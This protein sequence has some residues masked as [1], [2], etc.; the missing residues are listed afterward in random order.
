M[1][2]LNILLSSILLGCLSDGQAHNAPFG[3]SVANP[4]LIITGLVGEDALA[5]GDFLVPF[6][7]SCDS[8]FFGNLQGEFG[9]Q[10]AW[11]AGVGLAYRKII[12][13]T[14]IVG[15]YVF[16]DNNQSEHHHEFQVVSPGV[17]LISNNWDVR[18]NG[19]IPVS[20]KTKS[21]NPFFLTHANSCG[22]NDGCEF[23][24]FRGHQQFEHQFVNL[25]Q[26]G[27]GVDGEIGITLPGAYNLQLHAGGY[28]FDLKDFDDVRGVEARVGLPINPTITLTAETS[29]DNQQRGRVVAGLQFTFGGPRCVNP[30]SIASH[31]EDPIMRNLGTVGRGNG[32]PIISRRK[33]NGLVLTRDN[34]FFFSPTGTAPF[35]G[36]NSGTFENPLAANQFS[37][38]TVD[39]VFA[40]TGDGSFYFATGTY[41]IQGAGAPNAVVTLHDH[42][43]IVGRTADFKCSPVGDERPILLGGL[44]FTGNNTLDSIQLINALVG[45]TGGRVVALD[46]DAAVNNHVCNSTIAASAI[47]NG[48]L[49]GLENIAIGIHANDSEL[50][51]M[52][53]TVTGTAIV[54]GSVSGGGLNA[55]AGIGE[56]GG[57]AGTGGNA[58]DGAGLFF[59]SVTGGNGGP[60]IDEQGGDGTDASSTITI[61]DS[62]NGTSSNITRTFSNNTF[63]LTDVNVQ[64]ISNITD[65]LTEFSL[66]SAIGIGVIAGIGGI[67]G[68][69]GDGGSILTTIVRGGNGGDASGV[70]GIGG[71]GGN[72]FL[73]VT[74]GNAGDGGSATTT[75]SFLDN[76]FDVRN[77]TILGSANVDGIITVVSANIAGGIGS[78]GG[79]GGTGGNGGNGGFID[80]A[81]ATAGSGGDA[82]NGGTGG[83]GGLASITLSCGSGGNGGDAFTLA[84]F[85]RNDFTVINTVVQAAATGG[86]NVSG[87]SLNSAVG[88]GD[89]AG[90]SGLG[91]AG[92]AGGSLNSIEAQGG[93]GGDATEIETGPTFGGNGG[94][95]IIT[96]HGGGSGNGGFADAQ[97]TFAQNHFTITSSVVTSNTSVTGSVINSV[98]AATDVGSI[99]GVGGN[100]GNGGQGGAA[101]LSVTGG[102]GGSA[103]S[104]DSTGGTA[105]LAFITGNAG[106]GGAGGTGNTI[107]S[108]NLN[109]FDIKATA[110]NSN[111][112][113]G[114]AVN[115]S[116]NLAVGFGSAVG[117][118]GVGGNG[119][120][121][122][123][124]TSTVISG[125]GG[126]GFGGPGG[127]GGNATASVNLGSGGPGGNANTLSLTNNNSIGLSQSLIVASAN[128]LNVTAP[129][130][131]SINSAVTIGT[132][133]GI[134]SIGGN[135]GDNSALAL[136]TI[137]GSAG[138]GGLGGN[139]GVAT[140]NVNIGAG[141][142]GGNATTLGTFSGNGLTLNT[143]QL[144]A[145]S[146]VTNNLNTFAENFSASFGA[147]GGADGVNGTSSGGTGGLAT[148]TANVNNNDSTWLDATAVSNAT[149][150]NNVSNFSTN[151][152]FS[153]GADFA[154]GSTT[155]FEDNVV[156]IYNSNNTALALVEGNND[157]TSTNKALG[158][159][160]GNGTVI[161]FL[162][163]SLNVNAIV[164]GV[165]A[166]TN[167]TVPTATV[168]T[169][170]INF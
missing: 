162:N 132:I 92:G 50:D 16:V 9:D 167:I 67:G 117:I 95:A 107:A 51:I 165:N 142:N 52:T 99:A 158:L 101:T 133:G 31:L 129:L 154:F 150:G 46:L 94:T 91:G 15:T 115:N 96:A 78:I 146:N 12:D 36:A 26:V 163:S 82:T 37:Q 10:S 111:A 8:L 109:I 74:A 73:T 25:E 3:N 135:G 116:A 152:A 84:S 87:F 90:I 126:D 45:T 110:F 89:I 38:I 14:K 47:F 6:A 143:V 65:T 93:N 17:E 131:Y 149:V 119:G 83:N 43:S 22:V 69:G 32:I 62:G 122:G 159:F 60:G 137:T 55:A 76:I 127:D 168:G 71:N 29:Y 153:V 138:L 144:T 148:S 160:A 123:D 42:Q 105:D 49:V 164:L 72:A 63:T 136:L 2:K 33:D 166:G 86:A 64:G 44:I 79:L 88:I 151:E 23:V 156:N 54:N 85:N 58:D 134:N 5:R 59:G 56:I 28:F 121:A 39:D 128:A 103:V 34:I 169:G 41:T 170:V 113:V 57:I 40:A 155:T 125:N 66:N 27:P 80:S 139:P 145:N 124:G 77:S 48:D 130:Q 97:T 4:R 98:N 61:G 19:Y 20:E 70:D 11:Y 35:S 68:N 108:F 147:V 106:A 140:N 1:K 21:G 100:G 24:E 13:P 114:L 161:N 104:G 102:N 7:Q 81:T 112:T 120:N 118:G 75:T 53:S 141:G 18:L 157:A 30:C